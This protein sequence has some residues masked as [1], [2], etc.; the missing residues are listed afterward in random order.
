[1]KNPKDIKAYLCRMENSFIKMCF[2]NGKE[3]LDLWETTLK[4]I[5]KKWIEIPNKL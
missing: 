3:W 5:V 1:M 2:W 4:G